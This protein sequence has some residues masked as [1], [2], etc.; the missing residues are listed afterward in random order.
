ML[1][2]ENPIVDGGVGE[3]PVVDEPVTEPVTDEPINEEPVNEEPINNDTTPIITVE[4]LK[5]RLHLAGIDYSSY[6]DEDLQALI[7]LAIERIEAETG[8]P[9]K[10]PRLITEYEDSF[11]NKVYETDFYPLQCCEIRLDD[12]LIEAHRVDM[13]RGILYFKPVTP[14]D[15]EVKY[16]IQYTD[17][18]V[19]TGLITNIIILNISEDTVHGTWNSIREGEVSVTYGA[20]SGGLQGKVD[21]ALNELKGYYKPRLRL[22]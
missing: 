1:D 3:E 19:L 17:T 21:K 2:E 13:D 12:E 14:G 4:D 8:L 18:T 9:I 16:Q 7:E 11:H 22:L 15:L 6:T 20:G 10:Q 5:K